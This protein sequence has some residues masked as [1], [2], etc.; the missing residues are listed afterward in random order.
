M[1]FSKFPHSY[2]HYESTP[3]TVGST[4]KS[5]SSAQSSLVIINFQAP[6]LNYAVNSFSLFPSWYIIPSNFKL[7]LQKMFKFNSAKSKK[8]QVLSHSRS[9]S[10]SSHSVSALY[11]LFFFITQFDFISY[12]KLSLYSSFSISSS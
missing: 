12:W 2:H 4:T 5:V 9:P 10:N 3:A 7:S 8:N 11:F 6:L 1:N